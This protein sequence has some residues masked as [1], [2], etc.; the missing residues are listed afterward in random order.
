MSSVECGSNAPVA[1][2]GGG[3]ALVAMSGGVDSA[4]AAM[5]ARSGGL[6][7]E[8]AIM[9]LYP[10]ATGGEAFAR[11][12]AARLGIPFHVFDFSAS[13]CDHVIDRFIGE[14]RRGHTPNPCIDCNRRIKFGLLLEKAL[15]LGKDY[16][17]TGHYARI[18]RDAGGRY[19]LNKGVDAQKDQS[20]VLYSLTQEQLARVRFPLGSIEKRQ[21]R[22][23][24]TAAGFENAHNRESQD[25]CFIPDGDY[26]RFIEE[27]TGETPRKGRFIDVDGNDLGANKGVIC[28]TIGQRRGLGLSMAFPPYVLEIRPEDDT[29][30]VGNGE[31]LYSKTLQARDVN[32]I[33]QDRLLSPVRAQVKIRYKHAAAPATVIQT[34][35]DT[36]R[37]EFD[38]PQR[39]ITKGQTAVIYDGETVLGGGTIY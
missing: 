3:A 32:M 15:E 27:Y 28:Y 33:A 20:Y 34:G 18:S 19:L 2:S 25:I 35:E 21:V 10:G 13:F 4:V 8:G 36:L 24:A 22:D 6:S 17:I 30:V 16:L 11:A 26:A 1:M 38:E 7:C 31:L 9:S 37:V 12:A 5:L 23:M 39:A 29:V 14:Y